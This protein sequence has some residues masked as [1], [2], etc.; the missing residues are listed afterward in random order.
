MVETLTFDQAKAFRT[1]QLNGEKIMPSVLNAAM[2]VIQ[3]SESNHTKA[4]Q[5]KLEKKR[6]FERSPEGLRHADVLTIRR[7][8]RVLGMKS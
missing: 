5:A 6:A 2:A 3:A 8:E 4:V 7:L 1:R